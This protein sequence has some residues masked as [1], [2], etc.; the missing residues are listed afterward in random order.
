MDDSGNSGGTVRLQ[1]KLGGFA[2]LDKL[3]TQLPRHVENKVLQQATNK[4]L[5]VAVPDVKA[6]APVHT[7]PQSPSSKQ[8]GTLRKNIRVIRLR[9]VNKGQKGSRI[10]TGNAFWGFIIELGS[11]F[12]PASPWFAPA[13]RKNN[14]RIIQALGKE[15][16]L[17]IERYAEKF[18]GGRR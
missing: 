16:G 3:L 4:A 6:A 9:R 14:T 18:K 8:Y 17:G 5:R 1:H 13:I 15:I 10:D 7:G 12:I 2:E 11:R